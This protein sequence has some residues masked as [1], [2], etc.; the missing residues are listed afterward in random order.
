MLWSGV[1]EVAYKHWWCLRPE[2]SL[3]AMPVNLRVVFRLSFQGPRCVLFNKGSQAMF[4]DV[5]S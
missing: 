4:Q 3:P 5:F 1:L 2:P